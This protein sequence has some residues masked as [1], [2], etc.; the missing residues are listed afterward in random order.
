MHRGAKKFPLRSAG[1]GERK[2]ASVC[3]RSGCRPSRSG[4]CH[5]DSERFR[6]S[7]GNFSEW[8]EYD[9]VRVPGTGG[10]SSVLLDVAEMDGIRISLP[11]GAREN[12][13]VAGLTRLANESAEESRIHLL[14]SA[15]KKW[16]SKLKFPSPSFP[17]LTAREFP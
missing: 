13:K 6:N 8:N 15:V 3:L 12:A 4:P 5:T 10:T 7:Y 14:H 16:S 1:G 9:P 2:G 11:Q 17:I